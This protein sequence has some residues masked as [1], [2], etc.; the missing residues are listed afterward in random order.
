[1]RMGVIMG[2]GGGAYA[3]MKLPLRLGVGMLADSILYDLQKHFTFS[4][5][6]LLSIKYGVCFSEAVLLATE[7]NGFPGSIWMMQRDC[8]NSQRRRRR[9]LDL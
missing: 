2:R 5:G 9:F 4:S 1:M 7:S 8:I 6:D 3:N